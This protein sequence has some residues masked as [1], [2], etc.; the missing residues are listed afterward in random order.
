MTR[1]SY[2]KALSQLLE[3]LDYSLDTKAKEWA[4][5]RDGMWACVHLQKSWIDG[6][7]TVNLFAKDLVTDSILRSIPCK[8]LL[9]ARTIS[10]RIGRLI[11]GPNSL[12]RWWK[13]D[14]NG[15]TEV[16]EAV[17]TYGIPW[18]DAV[19]TLE[20]QASKWFYRGGSHSWRDRHLC[21][22]AVTLYR[23]GEIDEALALFDAPL[24]KT[25]LEPLVPEG[26]CV[27]RWLL[28]R[29]AELSAP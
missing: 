17:R 20:D 6:G 27:Q 26:L 11:D 9:G 3:P 16:A 13:S 23:M 7:M 22:L 5:I 24:P 28:A 15:P 10:V 8:N 18:F 4:R 21:D 19:Q 2:T 1:L 25:A 12:D 29:K 14:P